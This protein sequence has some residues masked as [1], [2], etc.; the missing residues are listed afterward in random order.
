MMNTNK[1]A[2]YHSIEIHKELDEMINNTIHEV[3]RER[4]EEKKGKWKTRIAAALAGLMIFTVPLNMSE[5]FAVA[6]GEIPVIGTIAKLLTFREYSYEANDST[7]EVRIPKVD[8]LTDEQYEE[9][10]NSLIN[11]RVE[12]AVAEG[13]IIADEYKEAFIATG[14]TEE[15]Y[16]N[17]GVEV[18]VD[19]KI[20]SSDE[21]RLSFLVYSYN[22][23]AAVYAS[24]NYYNIDVATNKAL[25]LEDILG[26]DYVEKATKVV[27]SAFE[28]GKNKE[29]SLY[30]EDV[31]TDDWK[32]RE[33][34]DFYIDESG[35]VVIVFDKYEIAAG[36]AGRLEFKIPVE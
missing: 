24:Y 32:V 4:V 8:G 20:L 5:S 14:G 18:K 1:N 23:V 22:S 28:E 12:A 25:T 34:I 35:N 26:K 15:A 13:K 9:K 19:Y 30:F 7:V 27:R 6:A 36:A 21:N 16:K 3:N 29:D 2:L 17:K 10:V 33:D 31:F 11:E